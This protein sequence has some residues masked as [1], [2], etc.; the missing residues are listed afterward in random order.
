MFGQGHMHGQP[1]S[2]FGASQQ[3][4]Y[5]QPPRASGHPSPEFQGDQDSESIPNRTDLFKKASEFFRERPEY[6][7]FYN[8]NR[9]NASYSIS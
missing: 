7:M 1:F 5:R 8:V 6:R 3:G 4:D 9:M 2:D